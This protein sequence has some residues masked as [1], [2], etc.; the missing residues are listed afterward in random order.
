MWLRVESGRRGIEL[1]EV[2]S[3]LW[4][5]GVNLRQPDGKSRAAL[6]SVGRL[7]PALV[8]F[9]DAAGDGQAE[10]GPLADFLGREE[11]IE[12]VREV[13]GRDP[14][15][16]VRHAQPDKCPAVPA[17]LFGRDLDQ[18][19][20]SFR[21]RVQRVDANI[22]EQLPQQSLIAFDGAGAMMMVADNLDLDA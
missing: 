18:Q 3:T 14:R 2:N 9:N 5:R 11:R 19:P 8:F 1:S 15:T 17:P 22:H 4:L 20:P 16:G 21:H 13:L 7:D 12:N 6:R 10:S